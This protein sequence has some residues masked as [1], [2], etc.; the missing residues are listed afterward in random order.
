MQPGW[1][2]EAMKRVGW[3]GGMGWD[4][5][6]IERQKPGGRFDSGPKLGK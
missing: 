6:R 5:T 4:W 2:G 1:N 3:V